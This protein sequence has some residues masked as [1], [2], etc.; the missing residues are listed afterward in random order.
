MAQGCCNLTV[1]VG[2][3]DGCQPLAG[4][5]SEPQADLSLCSQWSGCRVVYWRQEL[6][7]VPVFW[8]HTGAWGLH[9]HRRSWQG[10]LD[11][12]HLLGQGLSHRQAR[13]CVHT[14]QV[15]DKRTQGRG[16]GSGIGGATERGVGGGRRA[17]S[18]SIVVHNS[19][20]KVCVCSTNNMNLPICLC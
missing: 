9:T 18:V 7:R 8:G 13:V 1:E 11:A 3:E 2:R 4:P 15:T 17:G 5:G 16:R 10:R 6:T 20:V 19:L 14:V 12:N